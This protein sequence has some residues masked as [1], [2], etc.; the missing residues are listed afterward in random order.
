MFEDRKLYYTDD[1]ALLMIGRPSTLA[2]WRSKGRGPIYIR[3][4]RRVAYR[5]SDLNAWLRGREIRPTDD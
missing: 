1:P 5:G 4:G 2:H 3:I